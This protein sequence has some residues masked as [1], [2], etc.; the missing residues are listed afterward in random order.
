MIFIFKVTGLCQN[1]DEVIKTIEEKQMNTSINKIVYY[2][3]NIFAD[4]SVFK[5]DTLILVK[6]AIN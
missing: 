2:F 1:N 6:E 5:K 4:S 3:T